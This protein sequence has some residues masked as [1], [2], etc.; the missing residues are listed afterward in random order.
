MEYTFILQIDLPSKID[1]KFLEEILGLK[2]GS[3]DTQW[4]YSIEIREKDYWIDFIDIFYSS[5]KGNFDK[6]ELLNIKK[7][8]IT[9]WYLYE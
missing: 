7:E 1:I 5:L 6:L 4:N 2:G 9:I 8:D 3:D